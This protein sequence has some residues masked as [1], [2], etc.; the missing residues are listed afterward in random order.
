MPNL[1]SNRNSSVKYKKSV[2]NVIAGGTTSK[3]KNTVYKQKMNVM[4]CN[5]KKL[6][7]KTSRKK[8]IKINGNNSGDMVCS[9]SAFNDIVAILY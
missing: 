9:F 5:E 6:I 7:R 2:K 8:N 1:P 4:R 3:N